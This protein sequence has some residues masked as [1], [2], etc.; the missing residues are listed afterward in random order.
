MSGAFGTL[1][2]TVLVLGTAYLLYAQRTV[3]AMSLPE[4]GAFAFFMGRA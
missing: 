1:V 4:G 2:N 3:E